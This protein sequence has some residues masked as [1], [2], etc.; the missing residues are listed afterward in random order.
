V[1]KERYEELLDSMPALPQTPPGK[2]PDGYERI[3]FHVDM[4]CFFAAVAAVG[5][6]ELANKPLAICHGSGS[7]SGS[8]VSTCNYPAR[9]AGVRRGMCLAQAIQKCPELVTRPYEY[10]RCSSRR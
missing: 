1:W 9:A 6:P 8:E 3:L 5:H 4:D 10:D 2:V 7:G